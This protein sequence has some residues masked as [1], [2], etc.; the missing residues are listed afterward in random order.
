MTQSG[1]LYQLLTYTEG[2]GV[3][4]AEHVTMSASAK[5]TMYGINYYNFFNNEHVE[6]T[7]TAKADNLW[8]YSVI[9][10]SAQNLNDGQGNWGKTVKVV[11]DYPVHATDHDTTLFVLKDTQL[12]WY[13]A[14]DYE[15]NGRELTLIFDD[16]NLAQKWS[17]NTLTLYYTKL[18]SGGLMSPA[19]QTDDFNISFTP[20]NL[21]A[22]VADPPA[23]YSATNAS[24]GMTI[25]VTFTED[26][27]NSDVSG[28]AGNFTIGLHEYDY[29]PNG[30][31]NDTVRTVQSVTKSD[32]RTLVLTTNIPNISPNVG[33]AS[34]I[35]DGLGNLKGAVGPVKPFIGV[36]TPTGLTWKGNQ[37]DEE[38][39]EMSATATA[40]LRLIT[41]TDAQ[42][43]D[44]HVEMSASASVTLTDIHDL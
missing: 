6:M 9:P 44:E 26:I 24:D 8:A 7:A 17:D 42:S 27:V 4:G 12:Y 39:V 20:Q 19:V 38:H 37:C 2:I 30:T 22:P 14:T 28:M 3:R 21:V 23:F 5:I 29:V 40:T 13:V 35:Y 41:Y 31:L 18:T 15:I 10:Q 43:S 33:T 11:F 25:T 36:F 16:F 32:A 1:K 34:V